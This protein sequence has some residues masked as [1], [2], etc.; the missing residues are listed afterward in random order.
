MFK[1]LHDLYQVLPF[2]PGTPEPPSLA[3]R[4]EEEP[5]NNACV[6]DLHFLAILELYKFEPVFFYSQDLDKKTALES[7]DKYKY[8]TNQVSVY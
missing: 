8:Q 6:H 4:R 7:Q 3:T 1:P 2:R 5:S